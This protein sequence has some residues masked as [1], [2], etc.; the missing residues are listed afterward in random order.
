MEAVRQI[1]AIG[2]DRLV[3][4]PASPNRMPRAV[5]AKLKSHIDRTGNYEPIVV[6]GHDGRAGCFEI[7]NGAHRVEA[8][9]Q[10]GYTSA[11]CVEWEV[12]DDEMLVLSGTLNRLRGRDDLGAKSALIKR[13]CERFDVKQLAARLPESRKTIERLRDVE[14]QPP[15][16]AAKAKAFLNPVVF[17]LTDEQKQILNDAMGGGAEKDKAPIS[18]PARAQAITAICAEYAKHSI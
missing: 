3:A 8:L 16:T 17:F 7:I 1:Q 4:N 12:D 10:L 6:R 11:D 5:F 14:K 9:G 18:A 2:I 15:A 13:L